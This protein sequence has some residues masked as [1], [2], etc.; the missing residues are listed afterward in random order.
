MGTGL[1]PHSSWMIGRSLET[2]GLRMERANS[3]ARLVAEFLR[4][5]ASVSNVHYLRFLPEGGPERRVFETQCTAAGSTFS[6]DVKGGLREAFKVLNA[7]Q[8]FKLAVSLGGTESLAS[9][10]A[11][12]THSGIA[13]EVRSRLGVLD[14]TIR[15][16]IGIEHPDDLIADLAQALAVVR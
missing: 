1:D 11:T 9:H 7:L 4:D 8:V 12:M 5:H 3:N 2:L 16:S 15:V 13:P 6:F 10:P 14:S